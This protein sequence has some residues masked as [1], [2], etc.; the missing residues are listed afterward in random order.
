MRSTGRG[1]GVA[2][3][4]PVPGHSA[5]V[6]TLQRRAA[7]VLS[8]LLSALYAPL[9]RAEDLSSSAVP[10]TDGEPGRRETTWD[11]DLT[12]GYGRHFGDLEEF[13]FTGRA[14]AGVLWVR[15]PRMYSAGATLKLSTEL[16]LALGVEAEYLNTE[17][18]IWVTPGAFLDTRGQPGASFGVGLSLIGLVGELRRLPGGDSTVAVFATLR[19]PIGVIAWAASH[20]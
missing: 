7:T 12:A 16:P 10:V 14:R 15:Q 13:A 9:L 20:R 18:G 6:I 2:P 4:S 17:S 3:G 5:I 1:P 8:V 11:L 19:L